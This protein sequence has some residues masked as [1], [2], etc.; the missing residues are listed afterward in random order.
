MSTK[1]NNKKPT[2]VYLHLAVQGG[3]LKGNQHCQS[4]REAATVHRRERWAARIDTYHFLS[5][6][7]AGTR[8]VGGWGG[9]VGL[10]RAVM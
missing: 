1:R 9:G 8:W 6:E 7:T 3:L 5:L 2:V 10:A 4:A